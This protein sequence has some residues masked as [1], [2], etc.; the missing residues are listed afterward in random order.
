MRYNGLMKI[1]ADTRHIMAVAIADY[2]T[3]ERRDA[4]RAGRFPRADKVHD[5]NVR[6]RW[7]LF[8]AIRGYRLLDD[9]V[10]M[11]HIDTALRRIVKPL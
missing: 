1:D 11:D 3:P 6:Y 5:L 9:D 4:Y 7:D 2:D 10:N 8:Y